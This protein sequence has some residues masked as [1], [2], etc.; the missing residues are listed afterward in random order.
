[1]NE[2]NISIGQELSKLDWGDGQFFVGSA[3]LI[4]GTGQVLGICLLDDWLID[5]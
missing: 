5:G 1:M 4:S 3:L 2:E